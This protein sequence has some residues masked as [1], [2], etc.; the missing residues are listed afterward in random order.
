MTAG[1]S[2]DTTNLD[3]EEMGLV[4][5]HAYTIIRVLEI[6]DSR[7][8]N[9]NL[10]HLRNPW[11]N[12]E[13]SGD[14]GDSSNKWTPELKRKYGLSNEE[15]D[16]GEF[17]M[18]FDDFIKYFGSLGIC[19]LYPNNIT[20]VLRV[21]KNN[22]KKQFLSKF[23]VASNINNV[24]ISLYQKNPRIILKDGT[25]QDTVIAYLILLN[26]NFE[27][28][29]SISSSQE[30]HLSI[31]VD[32]KRGDYYIISDINYRYVNSSKLHGYNLTINASKKI[33]IIDFNNKLNSQE[34]LDKGIISYCKK[35]LKPEKQGAINI[36]TAKTYNNELP[37]MSILFENTGTYD[38]SVEFTIKERGRTRNFCYYCDDKCRENDTNTTKN[39]PSKGEC[40]FKVMPYDRNSL[41]SVSY[42][43]AQSRQNKPS[44]EPSSSSDRKVEDRVFKEE[45]EAI[46]EGNTIF[47]YVRETYKGY[48]IGL[49]NRRNV[50]L[51]GKLE[52]QGLDFVEE[53]N[54]GK[55]SISFYIEKKSK[56]VFETIL[57]KRFYGDVT[58]EFSFS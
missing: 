21:K 32:L 14:W 17:Y 46:D 43:I 35:N 34:I 3:L 13:F 18:S 44:S 47:Q 39:I 41:Y 26:S 20:T 42:S 30:M 40:V 11:G 58:F 15:K 5:A 50:R 7:G 28:V 54:K 29:S 2:G 51:R 55:S 12:T 23:N 19:K 45:P 6:R 56:L 27:Y 49:E 9:V 24:F 33:E 37:F 1:T 48:V 4:P 10:V 52:I 25:Y 36:Y 57:K 31:E 22:A 16:D 8:R 38:A 53:E